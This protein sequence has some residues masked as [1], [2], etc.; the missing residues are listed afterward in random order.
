[1]L[2]TDGRDPALCVGDSRRGRG[3]CRGAAWPRD[4]VDVVGASAG[5][6]G[7]RFVARVRR[8]RRRVRS[9]PYWPLTSL[10]GVGRVPGGP[11]RVDRPG[12]ARSRRPDADARAIDRGGRAGTRGEPTG[13]RYCFPSPAPRPLGGR[14]LPPVGGHRTRGAALVSTTEPLHATYRAGLKALG[15]RVR[16][17]RMVVSQFGSGARVRAAVMVRRLRVWRR[18][19]PGGDE[20]PT[21]ANFPQV[22]GNSE[23]K[24]GFLGPA[25]RLGEVRFKFN[26]DN[27][28]RQIG[29]ARRSGTDRGRCGHP[30]PEAQAQTET[31]HQTETHLGHGMTQLPR[32]AITTPARNGRH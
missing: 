4:P 17:R 25:G 6:G 29:F 21:K 14:R 23:V 15:G 8:A 10:R 22:N 16:I 18:S 30:A 28:L 2:D 26:D 5:A 9:D 32:A 7:S 1:M 24:R 27:D 31:P 20:L 3:P 12:I 13:C 19:P 11:R